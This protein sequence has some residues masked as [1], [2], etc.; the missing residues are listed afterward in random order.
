M[1]PTTVPVKALAMAEIP[2]Q[3][4]QEMAKNRSNLKRAGI[5]E[6]VL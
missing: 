2:R 6:F 4:Q 5:W 3:L 1:T